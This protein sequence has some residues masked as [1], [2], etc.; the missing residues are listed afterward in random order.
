MEYAAQV[1]QMSMAQNTDTESLRSICLIWNKDWWRKKNMYD[2]QWNDQTSKKWAKAK[3]PNRYFSWYGTSTCRNGS[4]RCGLDHNLCGYSFPLIDRL[5]N[6]FSVTYIWPA[7]LTSYQWL[8][9]NLRM[10]RQTAAILSLI[11]CRYWPCTTHT[12]NGIYQRCAMPQFECILECY[13]IKVIT[14][15]CSY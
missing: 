1:T 11:Q 14:H 13:V 3:A 6:A 10:E 15:K 8:N 7:A 2:S 9:A 12:N 4:L 5:Q